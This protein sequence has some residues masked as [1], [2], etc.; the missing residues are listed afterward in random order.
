MAERIADDTDLAVDELK[1]RASAAWSARRTR[2]GG[3]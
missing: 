1:R 3:A 2:R